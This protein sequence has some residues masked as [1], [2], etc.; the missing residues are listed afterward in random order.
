[1]SKQA[2]RCLSFLLVLALMS[3]C[4]APPVQPP[5]PAA[6]PSPAPRGILRV[7]HFLPFGGAENLDPA[8]PTEFNYANFILYDRLVARGENGMLE[9][10]LA[11]EWSS[12]GDATKWT[13]TLRKG[14]T[15]HDGSTFDSA[16]VAYTF[17]HLLDPATKSPRARTFT[18][19]AGTETP[20]PQTIVFKLKQSHADFPL[21]LSTRATAII[22]A[23][24]GATIATTGIGTGPF[25]LKSLDPEGTTVLSANDNYWRGKPGLAGIEIPAIADSDARPLALQAGQ[26]DVL[27]GASAAQVEL[28]RDNNEYTI[29]EFPTGNWYG[30]VM[31]TDTA[32]FNDNRVREAIRL[33]ADRQAM[34]DLILGGAGTVSCDTPIG[35]ADAYHWASGACPQDIGA[36]KALL[37]AAGYAD[38][39]ALTLYTSKVLPNM[40]PLAEVFQQQA[41]LAGIKVSLAIVPADSFFSKTW[42]VEPFLVTGWTERTA[43]EVF[44]GIFHSAAP[45]N[46]AYFK[47]PEFDALLAEARQDLNQESRTKKYHTAQQIIAEK[48]GHMIPFFVNEF[49]LTSNAV[50]GV[51]ARNAEHIE[52]YGITKSK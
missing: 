6:S 2:V 22:P 12:N 1:M 15:F 24:S 46:E 23:D 37:S 3:G 5:A 39:L 16:D 52:W 34:V 48:G 45:W 14:V 26:I 49:I 10:E 31:R 18:L 32:P 27:F 42:L 8:S 9:P 33:V 25:K 50:S 40:I 43:D 4:T 19:L 29:L 38:G 41:A 44:N 36:A 47:L 51:S 13:F 35:P 17:A 11:V 20:D 28:F 30:L 7:P 21:L